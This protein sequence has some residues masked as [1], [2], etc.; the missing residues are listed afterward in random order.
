MDARAD[1]KPQ[2]GGTED[3]TPPPGL[4]QIVA[5]LARRVALLEWK[6]SMVTDATLDDLTEAEASAISGETTEERKK[7]RGRRRG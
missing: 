2:D 7:R 4:P 1:V 5:A 6:L 3:G